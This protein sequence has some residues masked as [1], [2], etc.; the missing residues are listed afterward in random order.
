MSLWDLRMSI[1]RHSNLCLL[2]GYL[3]E[4]KGSMFYDPQ[5]NKVFV[6]INATFLEEDRIRD[7]QPHS[8]LVLNEISKDATD[9]PSSSNK[10]V[11]KTRKSSQSHPSQELREPRRSGR[12][13]HQPNHYLGLT[14]TQ[15]VI[16]DDGVK[17]P[18]TYKQTINDVDRDQ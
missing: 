12:V 3:K 16:L 4:P 1:K 2:V 11:D 5:D 14:K 15:I 9:M 17:D 7:H 8:K 10:V 13:V 6:S 18:L